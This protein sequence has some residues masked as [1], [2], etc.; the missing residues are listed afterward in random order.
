MM[1]QSRCWAAILI[2]VLCCGCRPEAPRGEARLKTT[3]VKGIVEV[4]G[5]P[6]LNVSV[7]FIADGSSSDIARPALATTNEKGAFAVS[8]YVAEDG[9]PD[10]D[11]VLTFVWEEAISLNPTKKDQL[12]GA[13][14]DPKKSKHKVTV[15][16]GTPIDMGVIALSTTGAGK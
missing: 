14:S 13:Y 11:Y 6:A 9:L 12:K 15:I 16:Q 10:G 4:D 7:K 2:A 5:K 8:T 1:S 3:P